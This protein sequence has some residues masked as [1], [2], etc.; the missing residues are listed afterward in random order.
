MTAAARMSVH[1]MGGSPAAIQA[2]G[3]QHC[4]TSE[5]GVTGQLADMPTCGVPTRRLNKSRTSQVADWSTSGLVNSQMTAVTENDTYVLLI[6]FF[7]GNQHHQLHK[8]EEQKIQKKRF[9]I[10]KW[11]Y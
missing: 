4:V 7:H 9:I 6:N 5:E 2:G 10:F 3:Y 8:A 1:V 11:S